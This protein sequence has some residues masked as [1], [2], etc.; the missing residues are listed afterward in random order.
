M[1]DEMKRR[2]FLATIAGFLIGVPV[3]VRLLTGQKRGTADSH[4][5]AKELN[6][7]RTLLDVPVT[8]LQ[9]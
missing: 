4:R 5:Y 3:A 6:Q 2:A 7:Y 1:Y 8:D 9:D